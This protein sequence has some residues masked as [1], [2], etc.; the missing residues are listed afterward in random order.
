MRDEVLEM[1]NE[2]MIWQD[3]QPKY[4]NLHNEVH[5]ITGLFYDTHLVPRWSWSL[6]WLAAET[7]WVIGITKQVP[8]GPSY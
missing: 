7:V 5:L 1:I 4:S 6:K 2:G 8:S 3:L